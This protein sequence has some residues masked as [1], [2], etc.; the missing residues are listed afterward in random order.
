MDI[1][2]IETTTVPGGVIQTPFSLKTMPD[3]TVAV[4]KTITIDDVTIQAIK[5]QLALNGAVAA[6]PL[7][8]AQAIAA[9]NA[10][11]AA[12]R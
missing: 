3:T 6:P 12:G 2:Y 5:E 7:T 8:T 9:L 11:A 1:S 4:H 10:A